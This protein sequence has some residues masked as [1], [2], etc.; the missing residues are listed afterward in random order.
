MNGALRPRAPGTL[1]PWM[2]F[3]L[4]LPAALSLGYCTTVVPYT[5]TE[6]GLGLRGVSEIAALSILPH[7]VQVIWSPILDSTL[8]PRRW[9]MIGVAGIVLSLA[10]LFLTPIELAHFLLLKLL[11]L[12]VSLSTTLLGIT[13]NMI[14]AYDVNPARKGQAAGWAQA[15]NLGGSAIGG[16]AAL[17]LAQREGVAL[18]LVGIILM[19]AVF[20]TTL[21]FVAPRPADRI[22]R[23]SE[24]FR[25][26]GREVWALVRSRA[27][28][29]T[30]VLM[31]APIGSGAAGGLFIS[32]G[33]PFHVG[34]PGLALVNGMGGGLATIA[35]TLIA[36]RV[37]DRMDRRLAYCLFGLLLGAVAA[38][39]A[40]VPRDPTMFVIFGLLYLLGT[41]CCYAAFGAAIL[42][43][44]GQN[45]AATKMGLLT[46]LSN[47][48]IML[49]SLLEGRFGEAHGVSGVLLTD[50]VAGA[51]PALVFLAVLAAMRLVRTSAARAAGD[52]MGRLPLSS[53]GRAGI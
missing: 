33:K 36:G 26:I 22:A 46:C 39:M 6:A 42:D 20:A 8:G 40:A 49:M 51:G 16:G 28:L 3:F 11:V 5:L 41:G 53:S 38:T 50:A 18:P 27:G 19:A 43:V 25:M 31:I 10:A 32:F 47:A 45:A 37:C 44:A 17:L 34:A 30:I 14:M 15:S 23:M 1:P 9:Y 29:F 7:T 21:G 52:R 24:R 35:G 4:Y 12:A 2:I 48:P 13:C